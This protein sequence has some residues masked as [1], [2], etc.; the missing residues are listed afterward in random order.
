[1]PS[2]ERFNLTLRHGIAAP[3]RRT[4]AT[5]RSAERLYC[6]LELYRSYYHFIR[7]HA[8]LTLGQ[9]PRTSAM[10]AG[11]TAHRWSMAKWLARP[12]Y[13]A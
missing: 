12:V 2:I 11:W 10:A 1:M 8:S 4:W 7:P 5:Y 13:L 9:Q 3:A 6:H